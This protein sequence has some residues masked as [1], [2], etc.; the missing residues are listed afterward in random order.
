MH[1][2]PLTEETAGGA[3][4]PSCPRHHSPINQDQA[5]DR[6]TVCRP[7]HAAGPSMHTG[8]LALHLQQVKLLED[9]ALALLAATAAV[10]HGGGCLRLCHPALGKRD[11]NNLAIGK[12]AHGTCTAQHSTAQQREKMG[13]GYEHNGQ[14]RCWRA[15]RRCSCGRIAPGAR[16]WRAGWQPLQPHQSFSTA[17][18]RRPPHGVLRLSSRRRATLQHSD[19]RAGHLRLGAT[20]EL[21][22]AHDQ[23]ARS[24][25]M[26]LPS[27]N[28]SRAASGNSPSP[29]ASLCVAANTTIMQS[30]A[31][32]STS[33]PYSS[34]KSMTWQRYKAGQCTQADSLLRHASSLDA[35]GPPP[36]ADHTA[37]EP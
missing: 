4:S 21:A 8:A 2:C 20:C 27:L 17:R 24:P 12:H 23:A 25:T 31:N 29:V 5:C 35:W 22:A 37:A 14:G 34:S 10:K 11:G 32:F 7:I 3:C 9:A 1:S 33:P 6:C 30:P 28:N 13:E 26:S 19:R 15:S 18:R 16:R 36:L